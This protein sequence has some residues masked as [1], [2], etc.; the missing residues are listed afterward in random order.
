MSTEK[1]FLIFKE[2]RSKMIAKERL[3]KAVVPL[4]TQTRSMKRLASLKGEEVRSMM[5]DSKKVTRKFKLPKK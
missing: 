1:P 3:T 4:A 2:T 5:K